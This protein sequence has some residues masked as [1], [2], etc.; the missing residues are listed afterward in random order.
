MR[1]TLK[2]L[3]TGLLF[4]FVL[5][6]SEAA[7]SRDEKVNRDKNNVESSGLWI[8]NDLDHAVLEARRSKKPILVTFRCIP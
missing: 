5:P 2:L 1:T 4:L 8:Y 7:E 3:C 6:V